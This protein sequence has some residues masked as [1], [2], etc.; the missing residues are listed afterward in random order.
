MTF[1]PKALVAAHPT[2]TLIVISVLV[3]LLLLVVMYYRGKAAARVSGMANHM[4]RFQDQDQ[5]GLQGNTH[6]DASRAI[7]YKPGT[8]PGAGYSL[9]KDGKGGGWYNNPTSMR[10]D[11][12]DSGDSGTLNPDQRLQ[13][14]WDPE[15]AAE[16]QALATTGSLQHDSYGERALQQ[17]INDAYDGGLTDEH[18]VN[19]MHNGGS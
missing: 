17:T 7:I 16:A 5:I 2:Y 8:Q 19:A 9:Q 15:A 11:L 12:D 1:D 18:L 14:H 6:L 4:M 3:V 10:G 13:T